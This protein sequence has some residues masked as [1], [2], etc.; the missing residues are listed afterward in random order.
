MGLYTIG[1]IF[2]GFGLSAGFPIVLGMVGDRFPSWTGT[3]FG[4]VFSIA[5]TG[6]MVINY[7]MGVVA[8]IWTIVTFPIV[9]VISA[10][11]MLILVFITL[12]R[13]K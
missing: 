6:N 4:V 5:L 9:Y 1:L 12:R 11:F 10:F 8:E 7:L 2:I 3:A 13:T